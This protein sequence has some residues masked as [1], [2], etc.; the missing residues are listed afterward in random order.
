MFGAERG[1]GRGHRTWGRR[2]P[3]MRVVRHASW[4][5][6]QRV[7]MLP[8]SFIKTRAVTPPCRQKQAFTSPAPLPLEL[9]ALH[10]QEAGALPKSV[11]E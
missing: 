1:R 9:S 8:I 6:S 11:L 7:A 10:P 5:G 3:L 4:T 2:G